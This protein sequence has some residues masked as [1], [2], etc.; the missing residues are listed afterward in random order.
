MTRNPES[1][2]LYGQPVRGRTCGS[3]NICC[4]ILPVDLPGGKKLANVKCQHLRSKGCSIY[5]NRPMPCRYWSCRWLFDEETANLRRPDKSGYVIDSALDTIL[6]DGKPCEVFQVWVDPARRDAHK[7]PA[8]REY[9]L[10]MATIY[11]LPAIIR[12][13]SN[14]GMV[15]IAP[16]LSGEG[17]WIE[18][19]SG[20]VSEEEMNHKLGDDAQPWRKQIIHEG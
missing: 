7:D 12:W 19:T 4:T 1:I 2:T 14:D 20:M 17:D 16:P 15:L 8:L 6:A 13:G 5:D 9:L 11:R 18:V 10:E 3:C